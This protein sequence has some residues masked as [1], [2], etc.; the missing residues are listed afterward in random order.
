MRPH[1]RGEAVKRSLLSII[2]LAG[3]E[4]RAAASGNV[5]AE[6]K[7]RIEVEG[8]AINKSLSTLGRIFVMLAEKRNGRGKGILP[9]RE[10]K[11]T[12]LL[13][14]PLQNESKVV[15]LVTV[16]PLQVN[17]AATKETLKFASNALLS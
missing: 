14:E 1:Q 3:S 8:A 2:D 10:T 13:Q 7:K 12:R 11:L 4:R 5:G 6:E 16:C 9:F 15:T 17:L